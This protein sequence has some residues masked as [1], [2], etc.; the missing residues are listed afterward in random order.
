M[1]AAPRSTLHR[2]P[3]HPDTASRPRACSRAAPEHAIR[4]DGA[5]EPG[6]VVEAVRRQHPPP[7]ESF[8]TEGEPHQLRPRRRGRNR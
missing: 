6:D 5:V 4:H 3:P 8:A 7:V 1:S 2:R